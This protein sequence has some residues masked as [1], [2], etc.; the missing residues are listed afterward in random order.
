MCL[1]Q[2]LTEEQRQNLIKRIE[3]DSKEQHVSP[4][5]PREMPL[6]EDSACDYVP[7]MNPTASESSVWNIGPLQHLVI[8]DNSPHKSMVNDSLQTPLPDSR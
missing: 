3:H 8:E 1:L 5:S 2:P 4:N 6:E 7:T